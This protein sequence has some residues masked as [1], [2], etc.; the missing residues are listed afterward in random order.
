MPTSDETRVS[1]KSSYFL[2]PDIGSGNVAVEC[3]KQCKAWNSVTPKPR[4]EIPSVIR[5]GYCSSLL[6]AIRSA[7]PDKQS[8][9]SFQLFRADCEPVSYTHLTLP[10][11]AVV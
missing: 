2:T 4:R 6:H 9:K 3:S 7:K 8:R 11:M 1:T 10:T 5:R